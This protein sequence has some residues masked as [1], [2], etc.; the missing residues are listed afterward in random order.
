MSRITF[1]EFL[2][3]VEWQDLQAHRDLVK[4]AQT[5]QAAAA[6]RRAGKDQFR[7]SAAATFPNKGDIIRTKAGDHVF[8]GSDKQ[9]VYIQTKAGQK[10]QSFPHGA[11][12]FKAIGEENGKTVYQVIE[13]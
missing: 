9:N 13:K 8:A 1:K 4:T 7:K 3:E 12:G 2:A 6:E 10:P 5:Q 11:F